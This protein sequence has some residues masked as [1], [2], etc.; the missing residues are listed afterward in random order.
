MIQAAAPDVYVHELPPET[1]NPMA[2]VI[3]RPV[4]VTYATGALSIDEVELPIAIVGGV[5]AD[6][7][8]DALK[9]TVRELVEM[10]QS[11]QGSVKSAWPV[12]ERN[13]RNVTG[14]GG[15]QLLYVELVLQVL[16]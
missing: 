2:V 7:D 15:V 11:L 9:T 6:D 3:M 14:A 4:T 10:D 1:L 12:S 8:I 13:W 5:E 16:M